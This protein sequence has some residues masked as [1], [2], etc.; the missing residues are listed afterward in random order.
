MRKLPLCFLGAALATTALTTGCRGHHDHHRDDGQ[1]AQSEPAQSQ[2]APNE[3]VI[4]NQW[5]VD[6]HRAHRDLSQRTAE[7]Q[8]EYQ[9]WRRAHPNGR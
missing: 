3:T 5:E 1:P 7:E 9:D 6:T 8:R 4:Y 2:P